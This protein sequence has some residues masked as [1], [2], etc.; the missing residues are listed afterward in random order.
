MASP[1]SYFS[2]AK[3]GSRANGSES[4]VLSPGSVD[5]A[6]FAIS[7]NLLDSVMLASGSNFKPYFASN[8]A[9]ASREILTPPNSPP[10]KKHDKINS[11]SH[12]SFNLLKFHPRSYRQQPTEAET[13]KIAR[14][15]RGNEGGDAISR[16]GQYGGSKPE[17]IPLDHSYEMR[18]GMPSG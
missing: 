17:K 15:N 9:S 16:D 1:E 4:P 2:F 7:S 11:P 6:T 18:E 14:G 5:S 3:T 12:S 8:G 10:P 13:S